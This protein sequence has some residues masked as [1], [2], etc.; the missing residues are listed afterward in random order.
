MGLLTYKDVP[1]INLPINLT[2]L[3]TLSHSHFPCEPQTG[4]RPS[5]EGAINAPLTDN[6]SGT[7]A[8]GIRFIM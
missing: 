5:G 8:T 3:L 1:L 2:S 7:F 4:S 6:M